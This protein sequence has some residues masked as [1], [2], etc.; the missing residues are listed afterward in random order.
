MSDL[1]KKTSE[2]IQRDVEYAKKQDELKRHRIDVEYEELE[3]NRRELEKLKQINLTAPSLEQIRRWQT[4]ASEYM[5]AAKKN[6]VFVNDEFKGI[7]PFFAR[8]LLLVGATTGSGKSTLCANIVY[9]CL[10]Q[11]KKV[12]VLTNEQWEVD[13]YNA[14]TALI[15]GWQYQDH[16]KITEEE[17]V[18]YNEYIEKLSARLTVIGD[19]Y[20]NATGCTTTLEGI[21]TILDGLIERKVHYDAIILDYFQNVAISKENPRLD[22]WKVLEML[23]IYLDGFKNRYNAP[24]VVLSQLKPSH[25]DAEIDFKDRIEGRKSILNS[26]TFALEARADKERRLT[27]WKVHKSRFKSV[28]KEILTGWDKGRYTKYDSKFMEAVESDKISK[29]LNKSES[30]HEE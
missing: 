15:K 20:D 28:G 30:D 22:K 1:L 11:G 9:S 16:D 6:M 25:K 14:V 13:V 18:V 3:Q 4:E 10:I 21:K 12:L 17:R 8:N 2:M 24:I 19:N 27:I 7:V 23:A 26:A 5:E 29:L